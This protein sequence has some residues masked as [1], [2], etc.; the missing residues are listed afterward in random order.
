M[1]NEI[2]KQ[3]LNEILEIITNAE[4]RKEWITVCG[5]MNRH[6]GSIVPGNGEKVSIGGKLIKRTLDTEKYIVLN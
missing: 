5:D 4:A 2:T 6:L 1:R 3:H